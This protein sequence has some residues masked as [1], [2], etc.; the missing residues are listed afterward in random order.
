MPDIQITP[1][2]NIHYLDPE[3]NGGPAVLLLHG[4][5]AT[6]D[7]W[8]LQVPPLIEAGYRPIA[9]DARGFGKSSYPGGSYA[10][11]EAVNDMAAL[12]EHLK[13]EKAHIIGI[14]MGGVLAQQLALDHPS[15]VR[16]LILI[17]TFARLRPDSLQL[18]LTLLIRVIM[19]HTVGI[20]KQARWVA[21]R[22]FPNPKDAE[23]RAI[24]EAQ[25]A[26]SNP[27][28][29]RA[30]IRAL[31]GFDSTTRLSKIHIPT[32]IVTGRSDNVVSSH[33]QQVLVD[34]IPDAQQKIIANA[35]HALIITHTDEF[36]QVMMEWLKS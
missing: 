17:N 7:S 32:L 15:C 20:K 2:L 12:L 11:Q 10:I 21:K 27:N 29:Y 18:W 22:L 16:K 8:Q 28:G 19:L 3:P 13:I 34:Q 4:L 9:P 33:L 1:K 23:L 35:G 25:V 24:F 26:Q 14:S 6:G 31:A 5:G 36:N 30:A